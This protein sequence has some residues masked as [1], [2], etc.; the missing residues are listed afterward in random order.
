MIHI[1]NEETGEWVALHPIPMTTPT[2]LEEALAL[3]VN[4]RQLLAQANDAVGQ[5]ELNIIQYMEGEGA[6]EAVGPWVG[7]LRIVAVKGKDREAIDQR[8]D[9]AI[10]HGLGEVGVLAADR[11]KAVW[12]EMPSPYYKSNGTELNKLA[13]RGTAIR[14]VI[15]DNTIR[16]LILGR[17]ELR[18]ERR[19]A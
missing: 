10:F 15:E 3:L 8:N 7:D 19:Q 9:E 6:T 14:K 1:H 5:L 4:A 17:L 12:Y 16:R 18:Q 13:N 2:G 11:D